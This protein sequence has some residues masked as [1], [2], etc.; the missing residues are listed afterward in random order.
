M[1]TENH[2]LH[3]LLHVVI[4]TNLQ[5]LERFISM[6]QQLQSDLMSDK[7]FITNS[8]LKKMSQY[9]YL[10]HIAE[11]EHLTLLLLYYLE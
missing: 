11:G 5:T 2:F 9:I 4:D 3:V 7:S 6:N 1:H 8:W 10:F